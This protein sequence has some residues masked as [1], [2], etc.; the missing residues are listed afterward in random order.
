MSKEFPFVKVPDRMLKHLGD[1]DPGTRLYRRFATQNDYRAWFSA[2]SKICKPEGMVSPGGAAGYARVS[3]AGVHKRLK[4]GRLTGFI[5][6]EIK[7]SIFFKDRKK[8]VDGRS[9][10]SGYIPVIECKAWAAELEGK[11]V[12]ELEKE[13]ISD[14]DWKGKALMAP[15]RRKWQRKVKSEKV[16]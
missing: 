7:D 6:H 10:S 13:I 2:A 15:P 9:P 14:Y 5:F 8:L 4:E 1:P 16:P 12:E 11:T 3:R